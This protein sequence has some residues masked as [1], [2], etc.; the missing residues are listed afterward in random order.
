MRRV[1]CV[2]AGIW[3]PPGWYACGWWRGGDVPA[4]FKHVNH[5]QED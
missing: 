1:W 2:K 3:M 4:D 5:L